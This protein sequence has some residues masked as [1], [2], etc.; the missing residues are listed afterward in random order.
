MDKLTL[1]SPVLKDE[2]EAREYLEKARWPN[3]AECP[4]C[5][6]IGDHYKITGKATSNSPARKGV[7][8]CSS[9]RK[10]FSVTVGTIFEG[11]H[12]PLNIWLTAIYLLCSSKKGMSAHQLHRT[13]NVTYKSAWFMAHRIRHALADLSGLKLSGIVEADETYIGGKS[14]GTRGRGAKKK[15][16]VFA[17]VERNGNVISQPVERVTGANLKKI[18]K[19]NVEKSAT[20]MTDDYSSYKGLKKDFADHKVIRHSSGE[21]VKGDTHTNTIEGYFSILKRGIIG[22][23]HH[24]DKHHLHRYLNEFDFRYNNRKSKDADNT[25]TAIMA[26]KGKRLMYRESLSPKN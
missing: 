13:L 1:I 2:D 26:T 24:V 8:K 18:I 21:Y 14:T 23:Y 9:C 11:S 22:I 19:E 5:G 20:M 17:L 16:P 10:Q 7:W 12:I 6:A 25:I 3:G 15:V 4:H